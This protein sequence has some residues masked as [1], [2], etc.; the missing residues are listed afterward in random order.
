M[1][2]RPAEHASEQ[3]A[4]APS[5]RAREGNL[6][7]S[8]PDLAGAP[9]PTKAKET[10]EGINTRNTTPYATRTLAFSL[11]EIG[12]V[13]ENVCVYSQPS[14]SAGQSTRLNSQNTEERSSLPSTAR[15]SHE[16]HSTERSDTS[17]GTKRHET[18]AQ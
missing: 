9:D 6:S 17:F 3:A 8:C 13:L 18:L 4:S 16:L 2:L 7:L 12:R 1:A 15:P 14:S 10:R 11:P 5:R